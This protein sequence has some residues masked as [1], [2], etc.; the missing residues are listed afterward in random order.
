MSRTLQR[1]S[2][3]NSSR[4]PPVTAANR[5]AVSF[6]LKPVP[7]AVAV[8]L[9]ALHGQGLRDVAAAPTGAQV[10]AGAA[11]IRQSGTQTVINQSTPRAALNWQSFGIA[12]GEAVIFRQPSSAAVALN[13]VVGPDPSAIFGTLQANGHVFLIN[14]NGVLFGR[15]ANVDVAGLVASTLNLSNN[16]FMAGRYVFSGGSGTGSVIIHGTLRAA[17]GG[18]VALL[19]N[20]VSNTGTITAANGTVALGAGESMVLDFHGDGLLSLKVNA[21]AARARIDHSGEIHAEGGAV[22]MSAAAKSALLDT[23]LNV[24]RHRA[25]ARC[26]DA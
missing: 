15:G 22:I 20:Q 2:P 21:T 17:N 6:V 5:A 14:P 9:L 24:A 13:R 12:A 10:T 19:G 25:G 18:Y 3:V 11:T 1:S 8:A 26:V 4:V 7:A 23:V 16:D